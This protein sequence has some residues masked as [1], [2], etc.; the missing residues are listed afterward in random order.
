MG[1]AVA[2]AAVR[3]GHEVTLVL[4]EGISPPPGCKV[5]RF[6][7][8]GD[9]ADALEECFDDCDAL[10]M[11]AAVGD[12][13][14][15]ETFPAKLSRDGGAVT[16]KLVP[17]EDILAGLGR[18]KRKGQIVVAF[19]VED[20]PLEETQARARDKMVR[21]NA[22]Y[23]VVNGPS[24]MAAGDSYACILSRDG[25]ALPWGSRPKQ[26]LADRIVELLGP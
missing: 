5:V 13:R 1:C 11:A 16:I 2:Q 24:A 3:A 4:A 22:D 20:A 7:G 15:Q 21:K 26:L 23:V 19:A 14:P 10:V 18:R 6:V 25:V 12:F 9:L 17:V 8:V